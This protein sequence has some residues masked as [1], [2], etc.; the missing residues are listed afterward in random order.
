METVYLHNGSSLNIRFIHSMWRVD[1][2]GIHYC[3]QNISD[4]IR[5]VSECTT[6]VTPE[7]IPEPI[8][9]AADI[10]FDELKNGG[11]EQKQRARRTL[12]QLANAGNESAVHFL[13]SL[14]D[15]K[16]SFSAKYWAKN[17]GK[18][19]IDI[20]YADLSQHVHDIV[21]RNK[22]MQ[23]LTNLFIIGD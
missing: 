16:L 8:R 5:C 7:S 13:D 14:P 19:F 17:I 11:L 12:L 18:D 21:L 20:T 2:D 9:P 10:L 3:S 4:L 22:L 15:N 6:A 1:I 23:E